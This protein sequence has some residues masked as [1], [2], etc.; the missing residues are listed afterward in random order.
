MG[1]DIFAGVSRYKYVC[2]QLP[3]ISWSQPNFVIH[4]LGHRGQ[5]D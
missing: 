5:G 2:E 4:T 3:G 1:G